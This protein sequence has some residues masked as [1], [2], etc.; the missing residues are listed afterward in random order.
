MIHEFV[1]NELT[2]LN[3]ETF[4]LLS[5]HRLSELL[6]NR[7]IIEYILKDVEVDKDILAKI[8]EDI[9]KKNN[10]Q[11]EDE[12]LTWLKKSNV[13]ESTF[14]K[15][16]S[17]NI[18]RNKYILDNFGKNTE[19]LFL[20]RQDALDCATYSLLRVKDIYL[21]NE[22]FL[23]IKEGEALFGDMAAKYSEGPEKHTRGIIGP[24]QVCA[25]HPKIRELKRTT[26]IGEIR[27]PCSLGDPP[28]IIL[29]RLEGLQ[30]ANLNED[31]KLSL[32]KELFNTW[33]NEQSSSII[34]SL[35]VKYNLIN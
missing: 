5:K 12:F 3:A 23:R 33:L 35:K 8:K 25:G 20:K 28:L 6:V 31:T 34:H 24:V 27:E 13:S 29:F 4:K 2:I 17:Y 19:S 32:A 30:K 22:L 14:F 21:A 9:F 11:N 10:L 7:I 26:S 15:D 16:I 18:R 1:E